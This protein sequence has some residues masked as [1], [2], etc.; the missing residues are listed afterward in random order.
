MMRSQKEKM[1]AGEF[2]NAADPEI[3]A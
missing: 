3:Q 1:L 2:Y